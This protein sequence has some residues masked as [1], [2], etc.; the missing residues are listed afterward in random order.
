MKASKNHC[1]SNVNKRKK[2]DTE[3]F[4]SRAVRNISRSLTYKL[5]YV[6]I[7]WDSPVTSFSS[8]V[9]ALND[10]IIDMLCGRKAYAF[11]IC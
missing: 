8:D 11:F 1:E 9:I 2:A 10:V 6:V 7:C 5:R 4:E 3:S